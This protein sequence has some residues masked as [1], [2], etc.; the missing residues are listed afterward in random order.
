MKET[1]YTATSRFKIHGGLA[2]RVRYMQEKEHSAL[3][4][5]SLRYGVHT[6]Y[7][8]KVGIQIAVL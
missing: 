8:S 3:H 5:L 6:P 4:R 2:G 1:R 7:E